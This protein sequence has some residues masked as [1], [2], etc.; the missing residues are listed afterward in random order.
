MR[1][2]SL[3]RL[4]LEAEMLRL[5]HLLQRHGRR[6]A[7][8]LLSAI[9]GVSVLVLANVAGWQVL[10][11]YVASIYATLILLGINLIIAVIFTLV[12]A[13]SSPSSAEQ[14]ALRIRR[15]ALEGAQ[16]SLALTAALPAI[17]ALI[18]VPRTRNERWWPLRLTGRR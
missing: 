6:A 5:R 18:G 3:L 14:E 4:A 12:A 13:R 16:S 8:G 7:F 2:V 9:F 15:E 1:S 10:R 11:L 17:G